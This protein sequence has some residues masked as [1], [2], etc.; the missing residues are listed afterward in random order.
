MTK[1]CAQL[2]DILCLCLPQALRVPI[3]DHLLVFNLN[4]ENFVVDLCEMMC[5]HC[6]QADLRLLTTQSSS[7]QEAELGGYR[8]FRGIVKL[9]S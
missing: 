6:L 1:V 5:L 4:A 9:P 3:Q 8:S 2:P 7:L